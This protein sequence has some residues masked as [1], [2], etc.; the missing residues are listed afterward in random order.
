MNR[1]PVVITCIAL[2]CLVSVAF[3]TSAAC[4]AET[5][6]TI[7]AGLDLSKI[8]KRDVQL[9]LGNRDGRAVLS[10]AAGHQQ[11]WPGITIAPAAG[12][13]DLSAFETLTVPVR[14]TG[15]HSARFGLRADSPDADGKQQYIQAVE[16]I[17]AGQRPSRPSHLFPIRTPVA[18][19]ETGF[20][21]PPAGQADP[22]DHVLGEGGD[23][24]S[25][26]HLSYLD[27]PCRRDRGDPS[28]SL[29]DR[30][31]VGVVLARRH[32]S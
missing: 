10:L 25:Y 6:L 1:C 31:L 5:L 2:L 4:A 29:P 21:G 9:T 8:E 18:P 23:A 22:L 24:H 13:W 32:D 27:P 30:H 26:R 20:P 11:K 16:E 17:A 15:A 3:N 19:R 14:N 12:P 7:D 28:A